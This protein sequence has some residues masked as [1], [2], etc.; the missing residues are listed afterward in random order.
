MYLARPRRRRKRQYTCKCDERRKL[1]SVSTSTWNPSW[2]GRSSDSKAETGERK[3]KSCSF[4]PLPDS[5]GCQWCPSQSA[6]LAPV[7]HL[8]SF[9]VHLDFLCILTLWS[10]LMASISSRR[11]PLL[12]L[13]RFELTIWFHAKTCEGTYGDQE[14]R[15]PRWYEHCAYLDSECNMAL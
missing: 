12:T 14:W 10:S 6:H 3:R 5:H 13:E 8:S 9:D 7:I 15:V 4:M 1:L 11:Y 2:M